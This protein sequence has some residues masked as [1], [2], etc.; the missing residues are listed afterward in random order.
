MRKAK[1]QRRRVRGE[2]DKIEKPSAS[3]APLRLS[4]YLVDMYKLNSLHLVLLYDAV[5]KFPTCCN[6]DIA[7]RI[8]AL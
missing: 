3:S 6:P 4:F 2:S 7:N 5:D 8:A 1:P